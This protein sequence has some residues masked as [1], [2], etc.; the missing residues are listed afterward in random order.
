MRL[1]GVG[2]LPPPMETGRSDVLLTAI[3]SSLTT[4]RFLLK[5]Q[6]PFI[7]S[8]VLLPGLSYSQIFLTLNG[9]EKVDIA[10]LTRNC[11]AKS[12]AKPTLA[13]YQRL[14]FLVSNLLVLCGIR[15]NLLC[16]QRTIAVEFKADGE[17]MVGG[18]VVD[19]NKFWEAVDERLG[20]Y[21]E[22]FPLKEDRQ[23]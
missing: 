16:D 6:V 18:K 5:Q 9:P 17:V 14:A 15:Y 4:K 20:M 8:V 1:L 11:I 12:P 7:I 10:R 21:Y 23:M 3:G 19:D 22:L 2:D 13:M